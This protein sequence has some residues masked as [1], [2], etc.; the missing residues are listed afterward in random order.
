MVSF[1]KSDPGY[2]KLSKI[3]VQD[4]MTM[5][6]KFKTNAYSGLIFYLTDDE[7]ESGISLSII[8]GKLKLISQLQELVSK[9]N[10]FNDSQWHVVSITHN[11]NVTRLD[12]DDYGFME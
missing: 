2:I 3:H 11:K 9:E 10:N 6:L 5:A 7:Q 4:D 12:F 1:S 8:N